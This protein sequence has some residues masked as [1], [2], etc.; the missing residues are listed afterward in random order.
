MFC[1]IKLKGNFFGPNYATVRLE[2]RHVWSQTYTRRQRNDSDFYQFFKSK[3]QTFIL[4]YKS[5]MS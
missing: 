4:T 3:F 5:S 2:M 1:E